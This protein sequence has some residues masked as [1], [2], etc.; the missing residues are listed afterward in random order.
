MEGHSIFRQPTAGSSRHFDRFST[1]LKDVNSELSQSGAQELALPTCICMGDRSAGKSSSME[2]VTKCSIFPVDDELC[3]L[4]PIRLRLKKVSSETDCSVSVT[5][6]GVTTPLASRDDV[7]GR[8]QQIMRGVN[9][10]SREELTVQICQ[11]SSE[12]KVF[13]CKALHSL[14]VALMKRILEMA[15][16]HDAQQSH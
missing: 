4:M 2:N 11:V 14:Q 10:I 5:Y 1:A 7:L 13:V 3:T 15:V 6:Q 12:G 16:M 9:G 8:V